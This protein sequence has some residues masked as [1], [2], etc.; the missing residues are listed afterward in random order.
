MPR[1]VKIGQRLVGEGAPVYVIA[2]VGINHN[3]D[4][5]LARRL[6]DAAVV[7]GCD[8]VKFQK[9]T[10]ELCVPPEQR[11]IM[12]ETPWGLMTYLDYRQRIELDHAAYV[13]IDHYCRAKGIAWFASCWDAPSVDLIETFDPVCHKIASA[14]L[15][16]ARLLERINRTGRPMILSTGMSTWDEIGQAVAR[17]DPQRLLIAH[18]TS[19]YPCTP[20]ELNLKMIHTLQRAFANPI[21]YSGHE[22]GLQT[23]LAAVAMGACFIERHITLDRAMWGSDQAASVEPGGFARLVRDIRVIERALGDGLKHVYD[24]ELPSRA[25]LRGPAA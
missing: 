16:D 2:E 9:R 18:A 14:S 15:T 8:A 23:T 22:V 21:G 17:L 20:D 13:E 19:T 3:G 24:S 10:P 1:V 7:A 12:R 6:I 25:R 5:N 11:A 4:L